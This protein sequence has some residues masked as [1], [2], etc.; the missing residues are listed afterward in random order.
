LGISPASAATMNA[1][2]GSVTWENATGRAPYSISRNF[3]EI[4]LARP[5]I[6][7]RGSLEESST[8]NVSPDRD[9]LQTS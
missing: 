2:A 8:G 4:D 7:G 5:T 9:E 1:C 6:E 3:C